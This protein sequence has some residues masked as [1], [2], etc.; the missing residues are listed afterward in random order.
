MGYTYSM[1]DLPLKAKWN[2][3]ALSES[4]WPSLGK[5]ISIEGVEEAKKIE[6]VEH[7]IFRKKVGDIVEDYV[8]CT[9]RV[10]FI[11]T[12]GNTEAQAWDAMDKAQNNIRIVIE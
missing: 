2:K 11:I 1:G 7:I 3:V 10:C 4:L 5:I 8:D 12:S 6:G 9:K